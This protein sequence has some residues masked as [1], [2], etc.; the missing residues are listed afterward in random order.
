MC[1]VLMLKPLFCAFKVRSVLIN[2]AT[3]KQVLILY[4]YII[5]IVIKSSNL[6]MC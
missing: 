3:I 6:S 5:Q 2:K 1:P 4:P